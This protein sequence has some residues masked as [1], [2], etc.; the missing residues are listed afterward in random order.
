MEG[1][2]REKVVLQMIVHVPVE[3]PK[4]G[5]HVDRPAIESVIEDVLGE[6]GV[7]GG[8]EKDTESRPVNGGQSDEQRGEND[9]DSPRDT[10]AHTSCTAHAD[11]RGHTPT[12]A[13]RPR[14]PHPRAGRTPALAT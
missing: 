14:R 2:R 8:R 12:P 10:A 1:N 13:A 9:K 4:D 5:I 7:L 11:P 3:K 6:T